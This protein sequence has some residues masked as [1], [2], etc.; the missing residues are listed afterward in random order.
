[1]ENQVENDLYSVLDMKSKGESPW[2]H[3]SYPERNPLF[4]LVTHTP[5]P[6]HEKNVKSSWIMKERM[7]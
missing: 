4:H 5:S 7:I 3:K 6:D 2:R 1:M